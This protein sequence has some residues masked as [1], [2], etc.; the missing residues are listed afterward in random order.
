MSAATLEHAIEQA[1]AVREILSQFNEEDLHRT[2]RDLPDIIGFMKKL[3]RQVVKA[4]VLKLPA[5]KYLVE[6]Y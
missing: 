3:D 4:M 5:L 1:P 2:I 6:D